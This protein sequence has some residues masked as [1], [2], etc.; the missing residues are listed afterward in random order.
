MS[1]TAIVSEY[2]PFHNG[3][4]YNLDMAKRI[5]ACNYT[6]S[7]MSGSFMQRGEPALFDKWSRAKMA[8][9]G[10]LDLVI[11][12]PVIY[13]CQPAEN[14]AYGAIKILKSLN[15]V[16]YLCFGSESGNIDDLSKISKILINESNSFKKRINKKLNQG[17]SY[18]KAIGD[19]INSVLGHN[20]IYPNNILGIEYIK[21]LQKQNS[22]IKPITIKRIK[23]DYSE[24]AITGS[25]SSATA[26]RKELGTCGINNN[27]ILSIPET[28][29]N[30]IKENIMKNKGPIFYEDFINLV[31]Y[32]LRKFDVT[33]LAKLPYM[34]EGIEYRLKNK[35]DISY[36]LNNLISS[37]KTKR[38]TRTYIQRML[39][40]LLLGINQKD[41]LQS[42]DENSPVYIRILAFN[43]KG[44]YLLRKIKSSASSPII[45]K[46]A[47]FKSENAFLNRMLELDILSTDIYNLAIKNPEHK[48]ANQDFLI[49]PFFIE[50]K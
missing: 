6:I 15:I 10:G 26:I 8:V 31:L 16:D 7:V 33:E 46:T 45:I 21:A 39:C 5:T 43:E 47:N 14:F 2:N 28:S 35:G 38:Y 24:T 34:K 49:S 41:V 3:H 30:I 23:N 25:I 48:I 36:T 19:T 50:K 32:Q 4:K 44:R 22:N 1:V 13:S 9:L 27:I 11:E 29:L 18:S 12:L 42:K 37:I 20:T 17:V 40:H